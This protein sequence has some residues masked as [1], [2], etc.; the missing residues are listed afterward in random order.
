[1]LKEVTLGGVIAILLFLLIQGYNIFPALLIGGVF[2]F[3]YN[4]ANFKSGGYDFKLVSTAK[5]DLNTDNNLISFEEIGGQQ[6]AINELKEALDFIKKSKLVD[7]LGI[8]PLKGIM[9]FGPPGTGKTL[10]AKAAANYTDSAFV[11]A[12]GSEF[13]EMYAGVGAQRVRQLFAKARN[14]ALSNNKKSSIIFIDEIEVLGGKRGQNVGHMEYDQTI[15]QLLVE[16]DGLATDDK[17][18]I[19]VIAATNR[20]DMLDPALL[21]PGRFDRLVRVDL[22]DKEGRLQI[23]KIHTKNKPLSKNVSLEKIAQETFGF[24]GAHLESVA[25]EA[26]IFALREQKQQIEEKHF[27]E[28]IDKVMLGEK[29]DKRPNAEE[30]YRVAVHEIGHALISEW[31]R[32]ESVSTITVSPRGQAL[33]YMRQTPQDDMYLYTKDII[34]G[35][36][37]V[38]LGGMVSEQVILRNTSTGAMG[39]LKEAIKLAYQII[40]AGMSVLGIVDL[41]NFPKDQMQSVA[42]DIINKKQNEVYYYLIQRKDLIVSLAKTLIKDEVM[43]GEKL[44]ETIADY[45]VVDQLDLFNDQSA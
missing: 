23:L 28:A 9:L 8:R 32:P 33:G 19:L 3:L 13:I 1:M 27:K 36:I 29:L 41:D 18:R 34:E 4:F 6:A 20:I 25:N 35:D 17:V 5:S 42:M 22:P 45:K 12:S 16:M 11:A 30:M 26:A 37:A 31:I 2:V 24:S 21:R 10:L 7:S 40:E 43:S 15:N 44:R 14:L 39:D 38:C